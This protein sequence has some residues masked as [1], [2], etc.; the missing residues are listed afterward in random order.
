MEYTSFS[1]CDGE[2]RVLVTRSAGNKRQESIRLFVC[3]RWTV[4]LAI[5]SNYLYGMLH[6]ASKHSDLSEVMQMP[7]VQQSC[8]RTRHV[9]P[10]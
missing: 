1:G 8:L 6:V 7:A 9:D 3:L 10:Q 5:P 4:L 2:A